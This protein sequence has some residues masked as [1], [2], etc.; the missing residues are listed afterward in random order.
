M[1]NRGAARHQTRFFVAADMHAVGNDSAA[2]Q[3]AN[4]VERAQIRVARDRPHGLYFTAIFRGMRVN[5]NPI[6]ARAL[7]YGAK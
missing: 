1:T 3:A 2:V 6:G 7:T 5:Q 4:L